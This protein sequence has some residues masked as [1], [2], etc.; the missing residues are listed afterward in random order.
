MLQQSL[1]ALWGHLAAIGRP[2]VA[3]RIPGPALE[4][5]KS[6]FIEPIP[7]VVAQWFNWSNGAAYTP[8]QDAG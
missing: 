7:D 1:E 5:V 4:N 8:G 2:V 6:A 3:A